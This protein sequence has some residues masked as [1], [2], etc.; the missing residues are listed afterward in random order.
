MKTHFISVIAVAI[1]GALGAVLRFSVD[2]PLYDTYFPINTIIVNLIGSL[3]LGV[4]TAVYVIK[5]TREWIKAGLGVGFCGGFTT[6]SALANDAVVLITNGD[7]LL[8]SL[9]LIIS[10]IGGIGLA[11]LGYVSIMKWKAGDSS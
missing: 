6:M 11:V 5:N 3:I 10:V 8:F 4:L 9:Y 7:V 2:L 1:G